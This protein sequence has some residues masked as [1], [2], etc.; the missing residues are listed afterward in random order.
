MRCHANLEK[1]FRKFQLREFK[2][3]K[4]FDGPRNYDSHMFVNKNTTTLC[5]IIYMWVR[6]VAR[7][8]FPHHN[9]TCSPTKRDIIVYMPFERKLF[10]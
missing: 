6:K 1:T 4:E 3:L 2:N 10:M 8:R 7:E 9:I 5:C